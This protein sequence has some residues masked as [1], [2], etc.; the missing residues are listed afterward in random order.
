MRGSRPYCAVRVAASLSSC[1]AVSGAAAVTVA[2]MPPEASAT[3]SAA[4]LSSSP[5]RR[6]RGLCTRWRDDREGAGVGLRAEQAVDERRLLGGS[7]SLL[8]TASS[9]SG[10][11]R[12]CAREGEQ[13]GFDDVGFGALSAI[14]RMPTCSMPSISWSEFDQRAETSEPSRR[15]GRRVERAEDA[16]RSDS[17][18]SAASIDGSASSARSCA[19]PAMSRPAESSCSPVS[20]VTPFAEARALFAASR[21]TRDAEPITCRAH[22]HLPALAFVV[23][24]RSARKRS[25]MPVA[26]LSSLSDSPMTPD[27]RSRASVP[28]SER[29]DTMRGRALGLDLSLRVGDDACGFGLRLLDQLGADLLGVVAGLV[30]DPTGLAAGLGQLRVVLLERRLGLGLRLFGALDAAGD[31]VGARVERRVDARHELPDHQP[32]GSGRT[33]SSPR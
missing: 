10:S 20:R 5:M 23:P 32:R 4:V 15:R 17:V 27:A 19:E 11:L 18:F 28:T 9:R 22:H 30:F 31:R 33:R 12:D 26:F 24:A 13:L 14:A 6:P 8:P 7:P 25:T 1:A 16:C 21:A 29:S 3:V 2:T